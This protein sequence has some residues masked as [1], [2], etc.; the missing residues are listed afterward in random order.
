VTRI[1]KPKSRA[2]RERSVEFSSALFERYAR[3]EKAL[4]AALAE[5]YLQAVSART[6]EAIAEALSAPNFSASTISPI[7]VRRW[8][9]GSLRRARGSLLAPRVQGA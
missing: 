6:I 4:A 8:R 1:G 2:P 7:N 3:G 9:G 5:M